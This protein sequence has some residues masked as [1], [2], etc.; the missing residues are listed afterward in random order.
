MASFLSRR[1]LR[2][3]ESVGNTEKVVGVIVLILLGGIVA[4]YVMQSAT[5]EDYLFNV[6]QAGQEGRAAPRETAPDRRTL[7][8]PENAAGQASMGAAQSEAASPFPDPGVD[9]WQSPKRVS[10]FN[11]DNLYEKINGRAGLYL[12]YHVSSLVFGTYRHQTDSER[13]IDVYWYDLAQPEN[14]FGIYRAEAPPDVP[15]VSI[16]QAGYQ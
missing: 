2:R 4:A 12:Q 15:P 11:P 8:T 7:P 5:N 14:A 1:Y 16:G 13:T 10:R 9:Q 3:P 6:D